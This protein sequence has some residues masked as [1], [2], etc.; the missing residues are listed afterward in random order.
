MRKI[1]RVLTPK[2]QDQGSLRLLVGELSTLKLLNRKFDCNRKPLKKSDIIV[3]WIS[4]WCFYAYPRCK[5][6]KQSYK[7]YIHKAISVHDDF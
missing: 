3:I 6:R 1:D 4:S 7:R 5:L 2:S